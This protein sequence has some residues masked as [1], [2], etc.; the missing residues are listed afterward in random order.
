M[1]KENSSSSDDREPKESVEYSDVSDN[2]AARESAPR[3]RQAQGRVPRP[4]LVATKR[5]KLQTYNCKIKRL[6]NH[7]PYAIS[8]P[9]KAEIRKAPNLDQS[10]SPLRSLTM[11]PTLVPLMLRNAKLEEAFR[12]SKEVHNLINS[13]ISHNEAHQQ[14]QTTISEK[15]VNDDLCKTLIEKGVP[16]ILMDDL[17]WLVLNY[18]TGGKRVS[19][20]WGI[21]HEKENK[22]EWWPAE[23]PFSSPNIRER[24]ATEDKPVLEVDQIKVLSEA[25]RRDII[26]KRCNNIS[27]SGKPSSK[28]D[29]AMS[30]ETQEEVDLSKENP[31]V[32]LSPTS[33]PSLPTEEPFDIETTDPKESR[34][35]KE[36][37]MLGSFRHD[38]DPPEI[39]SLSPPCLQETKITYLKKAATFPAE[40]P[41]TIPREQASQLVLQAKEYLDSVQ[42]NGWA[43]FVDKMGEVDEY[44]LRQCRVFLSRHT[45]EFTLRTMPN[46][47]KVVNKRFE[48][49]ALIPYGLAPLTAIGNG[50][51]LFNLMGKLMFGTEVVSPILRLVAAAEGIR[52]WRHYV[53]EANYCYCVDSTFY[54]HD[55]RSST[56]KLNE[57]IN[58]MFVSVGKSPFPNHYIP[59]VW[60]VGKRAS[61]PSLKA[62]VKERMCAASKKLGCHALVGEKE[63][64][65][66]CKRC[67]LCYHAVCSG[68]NA[69]RKS[70]ICCIDEA[71]KDAIKNDINAIAIHFDDTFSIL[72]NTTCQE[73]N[74]F[75]ADTHHSNDIV[76][77]RKPHHKIFPRDDILAH[78][79]VI[80]P[81][82][83]RMCT[84]DSLNPEGC[85]NDN[86]MTFAKFI[87]HIEITT[88][89][90]V[91]KFYEIDCKIPVQ[92]RK[93]DC[94]VFLLFYIE[95]IMNE[96]YTIDEDSK[97]LITDGFNIGDNLRKKILRYMYQH[98]N[99]LQQ[100]KKKI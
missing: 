76:E 7:P 31:E 12:T 71:T 28:V 92:V 66:F 79:L 50:D 48:K 60:K 72:Q 25:M 45:D 5:S 100:L 35:S 73:S 55:F 62:S 13:A 65:V 36:S 34:Y 88:E 38:E 10:P 68:V 37:F 74:V 84:L 97:L 29:Q 54:Y 95:S 3:K 63:E 57:P 22:P 6:E 85:R 17:R 82:A 98:Q 96:E 99:N 86:L 81:Y 21:T 43:D 44:F 75:V 78:E 19:R 77:G 70:F 87:N 8:H 89:K 91:T 90:Q 49:D 2:D 18:T 58:V 20:F 67:K 61:A 59:L 26:D 41:N 40:F 52:H 80:F 93:D 23:V 51:C 46:R 1:D 16:H 4:K 33:T 94:G 47:E 11:K 30:D 9:F 64:W 53:E 14:T 15:Y 32:C 24:H 83:S 39:T 42:S 56:R 27:H 69:N